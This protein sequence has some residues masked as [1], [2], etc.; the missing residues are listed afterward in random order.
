[1]IAQDKV[2]NLYRQKQKK[3]AD[4]DDIKVTGKDLI[5]NPNTSDKNRLRQ[6]LADIQSNWHDLTELLVQMISFTVSLASHALLLRPF[7]CCGSSFQSSRSPVLCFFYFYSFLL[8]DFSYNIAPP[9]FRSS[10]LSV[11]T[12]FRAVDLIHLD[13]DL[14]CTSSSAFSLF[15]VGTSSFHSPL[16]RVLCFFSLYS[17]LLHV[18][19]T[20]LHLSFGLP[21][22]QCP[23]TSIVHLLVATALLSFSTHGLTISVSLLLYSHSCLPHLPLLIF[24]LS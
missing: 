4:L 23:P 8:H 20:S 22:F 7:P 9:Q 3:Q 16:A 12:H 11:S 24:L 10:Y 1:M 5:D 2:E 15:G 17:F 6:T 13:C 19:I 18:F 21:I 14:T